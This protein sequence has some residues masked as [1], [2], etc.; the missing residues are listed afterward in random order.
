MHLE[1]AVTVSFGSKTQPCSRVIKYKM[2]AFDPLVK[3]DQSQSYELAYQQKLKTCG[4][5]FPKKNRHATLPMLVA[6]RLWYF[7]TSVEK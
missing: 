4:F 7:Y 5:P 2:L 6:V 1:L 3:E